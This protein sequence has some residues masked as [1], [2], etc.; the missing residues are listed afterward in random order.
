VA[1]RWA[2]TRAT[3][4]IRAV[5]WADALTGCCCSTRRPRSRCARASLGRTT[6]SATHHSH[7][8]SRR[9][10][11]RP[12]S[13]TA[14]HRRKTPPSPPPAR[15]FGLPMASCCLPNSTASS[16]PTHPPTLAP[17]PCDIRGESRPIAV[18]Q[19]WVIRVGSI[20]SAGRTMSASRKSGQIG[21]RLANSALC[22][23]RTS[24]L[25]FDHLNCTVSAEQPVPAAGA[26]D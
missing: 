2:S 8:C 25:L 14:Q 4:P 6:G 16:P 19:L 13:S 3:R 5:S 24:S 9:F 17:A 7:P 21:R 22:Q 1:S 10:P 20:C 18:C 11:A 23:K 12:S 26:G 15:S